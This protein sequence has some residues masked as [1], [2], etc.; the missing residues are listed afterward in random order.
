MVFTKQNGS[1]NSSYIERVR[2]DNI[3]MRTRFIYGDFMGDYRILLFYDR[4]TNRLFVGDYLFGSISSY[5]VKG[6][7]FSFSQTLSFSFRQLISIHRR[8]NGN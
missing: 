1:Y 5:S 8:S 7:H 6:S 4:Y 2:M 3:Q